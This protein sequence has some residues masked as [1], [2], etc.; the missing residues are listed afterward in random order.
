[1][2][3]RS[4]NQ[5]R[6]ENAEQPE[7]LARRQPRFTA[8]EFGTLGE[9]GGQLGSPQGGVLVDYVSVAVEDLGAGKPL[10][11]AQTKAYGCGVKYAN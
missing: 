10:R 1:M 5:R 3:D 2:A 11:T 4:V 6:T 9:D 7:R 8:M